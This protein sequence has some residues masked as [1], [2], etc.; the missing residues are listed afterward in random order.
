MFLEIARALALIVGGV[1]GTT[2]FWVGWKL[3]KNRGLWRNRHNSIYQKTVLA[4][5]LKTGQ[6]VIYR[7][8]NDYFLDELLS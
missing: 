2:F 1:V 7:T 8:L 5:S 6:W 3:Y 4:V